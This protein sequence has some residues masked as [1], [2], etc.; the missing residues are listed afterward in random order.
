MVSYQNFFANR[1]YWAAIFGAATVVIAYLSIFR[2]PT[3]TF[4]LDVRNSTVHFLAYLVY[5][6]IAAMWRR[7]SSP[8]KTP[9]R[10]FIES[11]LITGGYGLFLEGIQ[12]YLPLRDADPIDGLCNV[13]GALCG[14]MIVSFWVSPRTKA[15]LNR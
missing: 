10:V 7:L 2:A 9:L 4:G 8:G 6:G 11:A 3:V 5:S 15:D 14:A 13:L 12:F 1:K